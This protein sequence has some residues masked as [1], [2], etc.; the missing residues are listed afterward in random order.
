MTCALGSEIGL[1]ASAETEVNLLLCIICSKSISMWESKT[2]MVRKSGARN[3]DFESEKAL[4]VEKIR[5]RLEAS[6]PPPSARELCRAAG[7][8]YP[9]FAHYFGDREGAV[10]AVL[11]EIHRQGLTYLARTTEPTAAFRASITDLLELLRRGLDEGPL[12]H[13][14]RVGIVEGAASETTAHSYL[15]FLLEP[16]LVAIETRLKAHMFAGEMRQV[17]ARNAALELLSPMVVAAL[18]QFP[19]RGEAIR[20]LD[21]D[22]FCAQLGDSFLRSYEMTRS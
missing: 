19:L 10:R 6:G 16:T 17:D 22:S 20:P 18:H 11:Q 1:S 21:W 5:S 9:T 15:I 14:H 3:R 4:L 12:I 8:T 2:I 7:I 13:A